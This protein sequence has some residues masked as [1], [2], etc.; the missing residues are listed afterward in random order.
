MKI[1]I[2]GAGEVGTHLAKMFSSENQD[3]VLIDIN[4]DKL[5]AIE[6]NYD[7]MTRTGSCTSLKVLKD[8]GVGSADL[9]IAVT[10]QE[11]INITAC[12]LA[13]NLGALKTLARVDN[14][15]YLLPVNSEF[16]KKIGVDYLI[17]PEM[18]AAKEI[19]AS[20]KVNWVRQWLEFAGGALVLV[21]LKVRDNAPILNR[22]FQEVFAE[23]KRTHV[24]AIK[25]RNETI[26]PTGQDTI[27]ANDIVYFMTTG[28]YLPKLR[29]QTGKES[30]EIKNVMI[31]GGGR[32]GVKVAQF[33]SETMNVKII[34]QDEDRGYEI[35]DQL[36]NGV[37]VIKGDGCDIDLLKTEGIQEMDAFVSLT[38]SSEA[39]ILACLVAK[40]HGIRKTVA[41]IENMEYLNL[42]DNLDIGNIINKKLITASYIYQLTLDTTSVTNMKSLTHATADV[43]EFTVK[44]GDRITKR[45]VKDLN[46]PKGVSIGGVVRG[47]KGILVDGNTQ[48]QP[49]DQ[50]IVF[51][52][53]SMLRKVEKYFS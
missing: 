21:G 50:V 45:P 30:I 4:E 19:V 46:L 17:Y 53:S 5:H 11:S 49:G 44:E 28:D 39:N 37:M 22:P 6:L 7:L 16:F 43:I 2:A 51:S 8:S 10:S 33:L 27:Q 52:L 29:Q 48:I 14:Y 36:K 24:V 13:T 47:G 40:S 3:I 23:D 35:V 41:E 9:F 15:E 1:I 31:V 25:R 38:D 42:S 20:I 18:L 12:T 32:I 34:E 26:I